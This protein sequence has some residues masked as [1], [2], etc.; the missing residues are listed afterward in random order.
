MSRS[1]YQGNVP[2]LDPTVGYF[3]KEAGEMKKISAIVRS[4]V[5]SKDG[6][7]LPGRLKSLRSFFFLSKAAREQD[8]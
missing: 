8:E 2:A 7:D 5:R 6:L 4:F 1:L 3:T